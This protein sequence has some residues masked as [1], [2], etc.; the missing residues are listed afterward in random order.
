MADAELEQINKDIQKAYEA[1]NF[2]KGNLY[3]K[4]KQINPDI[5]PTHVQHF[6]ASDYTTQLTKVKQKE[7]A[8]G[9]IVANTPN[10]IWQF[11][12]L[13]LSRYAR[14]NNNIRYILACVDVFTRRAYVEAMPQKNAESVKTAFTTILERAN[15]QPKS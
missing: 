5:T 13:D 9:H 10:E 11:D 14:K 12:I 2:K 6:L 3:K 7:E 4:A 1:N 15:A 8:K